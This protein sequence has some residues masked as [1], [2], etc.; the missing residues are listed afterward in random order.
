MRKTPFQ[1]ASPRF[2]VLAILAAASATCRAQ[3]ADADGQQ[4]FA[5]LGNCKLVSGQEI[6]GCRLGYRIWGKLNAERSNAVLFPSWLAGTTAQLRYAVSADGLVDPA[7]YYVIAVDALGDGVSS[8][9][10]NSATQ[11]GPDFPAFTIQDMVNAEYRMLTE[12]L[13]LRHLHAVVGIS[14][15]AH[16][17][18][19]W[20]ADYPSFMSIA[21]PI[22]GSPRP[23]SRDLLLHFAYEDAIRSDPAWQHGRY[24]KAPPA[25]AAEI[26]IQMNLTTPANYARTHPLEQFAAIYN[27]YLATGILP[28]DANDLL[29]QVNAIIH[30]DVAHGGSLADAAKHVKARVLVVSAAQDHIVNPQPALDFAALIGAKTLVLQGDCG[31]NANNCEANTLNPAVRAFLDGQ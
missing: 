4:Q 23:N 2:L 3:P 31:H 1:S 6:T 21:I 8:S 16:Q 15:G 29:A 5:D 24:A 7:K 22:L 19:E 14:M 27:G 17:A 26:L 25:A 18:F 12:K 11:H 9:P 10:S 20:M 30:L 13:G 28:F